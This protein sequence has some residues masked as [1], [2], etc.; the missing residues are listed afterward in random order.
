MFRAVCLKCG[1]RLKGPDTLAGKMCKCPACHTVM[2]VPIACD[3]TSDTE[4]L[5]K[6]DRSVLHA[7]DRAPVR[8]KLTEKDLPSNLFIGVTHGDVEID[9]EANGRF[10]G[11]F[12][13]GDDDNGN[14]YM[15]AWSRRADAEA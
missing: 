7:Q 11:G 8:A 14:E 15:K 13:G 5:G 4:P 6:A 3:S 12:A 10:E 1:K 2:K 9:F